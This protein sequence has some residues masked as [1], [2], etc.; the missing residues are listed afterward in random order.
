M[1]NFICHWMLR[2]GLWFDS[3]GPEDYN[4]TKIDQ[5]HLIR[6][7]IIDGKGSQSPFCSF[8]WVI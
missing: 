5:I 8:E 3:F 6:S 4:Q 1:R 7:D 2:I